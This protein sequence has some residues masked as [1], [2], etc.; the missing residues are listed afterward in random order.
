MIGFHVSGQKIFSIRG[1]IV[2][3]DS[4]TAIPF[5]YAIN[6]RTGNGCMSD[7]NGAYNISGTDA[8]T[9][10]FSYVGFV[11]KKVLIKYIKNLN[12]STKQNL[13]V[14]M[15]RSLINL[16]TFDAVAFK[17]KPHEREYMKRVINR[18]RATGIDAFN[19]PITA[20][21]DQYSKKGRENRKLAAIFEQIFIEEQV[22]HKF[23]PQIL[24]QLT[25]DENIDFERFRKYCYSVTNDFI[26]NHDGYELYEPIMQCY[27]RWKSE[28]K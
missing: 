22:A 14:V 26:I 17:I 13:K 6:L 18:P 2:E 1:V 8:D 21:Y 4:T 25:G 15:V 27:R 12:D 10:V 19:S 28:G 16:N 3:D 20:L 11:K 5:A 23:N 7:Y 9:I 24:R